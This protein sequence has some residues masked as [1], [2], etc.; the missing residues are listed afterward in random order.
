MAGRIEKTVFISYRRTN[1]AWALAIYQNLTANGYDV[2]FD[3]LNIPSG[4]FEKIILENIK[5]RAHFIVILTPSALDR[6]KE[7][8][9]WLRREI[10]TAIN[11]KRNIIP[12]MLESFDFGSPATLESLTGKLENLKKYNALR[13]PSEYFFEA[14][15][16][17]R[18][19]FLN[20]S[21]DGV[22]HPVSSTVQKA[23]R[24]QKIAA[25]KE[26]KVKQSQ[27]TAQEWY[28]KGY[29]HDKANNVKEAIRCYT[30]AIRLNE[31]Y[32]EAYCNRGNAYRDEENLEKAILDYTESI[33][34]K[35]KNPNAYLGRGIA[36]SKRGNQK[37]AMLDLTEA[38][39]IKPN[40]SYAYNQRG[41]VYKDL[42][43]LHKALDDYSK[44]I[45]FKTD[46]AFAYNNRGHILSELGRIEEA[47]KDYNMAIKRDPR[48]AYP[49][50]N[51]AILR[52]KKGENQLALVDARKFIELYRGND[53]NERQAVKKLISEINASLGRK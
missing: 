51:R 47:I 24:E 43:E 37:Q 25:N 33:R 53:E 5:S 46:Y 13:V 15:A 39:K 52:K 4:D 20:V 40:F 41:N 19:Q 29:K 3:Y 18:E 22:L 31:D 21:L 23:I 34:L 10:E 38:L 30:E 50:K 17:L 16:K 14:M 44:A 11:E 26:P 28:E 6:C 49:Y 8:D 9:D 27:L 48:F 12:L 32:A 1:S 36:Y 42:G 7:P 2:F 35:P 45:Y